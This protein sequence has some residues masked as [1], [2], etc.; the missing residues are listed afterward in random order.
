MADHPE[1]RKHVRNR[2]WPPFS[3]GESEGAGDCRLLP[4][5]SVPGCNDGQP[6]STHSGHEGAG[7]PKQCQSSIG[8]DVPFLAKFPPSLPPF[9][10]TPLHAPPPPPPPPYYQKRIGYDP[11]TIECSIFPSTP[12][13]EDEAAFPNKWNMER[14]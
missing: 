5:P 11:Q 8:M 10:P 2:L 3:P 6:F 7:K 4:A 1:P 9:L 14:N 12:C 13:L